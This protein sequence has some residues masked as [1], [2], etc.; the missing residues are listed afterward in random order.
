MKI[1]SSINSES[2]RLF[3]IVSKASSESRRFEGRIFLSGGGSGTSGGGKV[4]GNPEFPNDR[5]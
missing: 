4:G 2:T 5:E 1:R 3:G